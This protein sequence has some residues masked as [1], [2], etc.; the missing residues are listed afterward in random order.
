[1][2][3]HEPRHVRS[4]HAVT[5]FRAGG[6][7]E[8]IAR[9]VAREL[10]A[11][12][13]VTVATGAESDPQ[14]LEELGARVESLPTLRRSI[15]PLDDFR[16]FRALRRLIRRGGY[17]I[18]QTHQAKAGA[19]GRLAAWGAPAFVVHH[20]HMASFGPGFG[21]PASA[22]NL[23]VE[24]I[25]ARRTD[26]FVSVGGDLDARYMGARVAS[27][28]QI[29]R[30][31]TPV[32][33]EPLFAVRGTKPL[34]VLSLREG[35]AMAL[36]VGALEPRKRHG[37]LVRWLT[38]M[39]REGTIDLVICGDGPE[40]AAIAAVARRLG[41]FDAVHLIGHQA[42][43]PRIYAAA[44]VVV[45]AAVTEGVCRVFVEAL[46]AGRPLVVTA[47]EGVGDLPRSAP[48]TVVDRTGSRF[49]CAVA[50]RLADP[51]LPVHRAQLEDWSPAEVDRQIHMFHTRIGF[52]G[53][54][55]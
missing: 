47:V 26:L 28:E 38:P 35:A 14:R 27:P 53:G 41:V 7:E 16:S 4:L 55:H 44:D 17:D 13:S 45:H 42:D 2:R 52:Q 40:R 15:D 18:V 9:L 51:G 1:M 46:A 54:H 31:R 50:E 5:R 6:S 25:C 3:T 43:M 24:R 36:A 10:D 32:A 19:L 21:R 23:A 37:E 11:G 12:W 49:C 22:V 34:P 8:D 33:L 29:V 20:I 39:L 48:V 30:V